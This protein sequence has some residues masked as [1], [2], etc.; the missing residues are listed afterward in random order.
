MSSMLG[1]GGGMIMPSAIVNKAL[2]HND[3]IS[4]AV[5]STLTHFVHIHINSPAEKPHSSA[6]FPC[7][8]SAATK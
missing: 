1:A 6:R 2:L 4:P 8:Q 3:E 5:K 7:C